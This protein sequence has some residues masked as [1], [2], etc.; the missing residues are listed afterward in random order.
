VLE[1]LAAQREAV[2]AIVEG[3]D[4]EAWRRSVVPTGWTP[5]GLVEHLGGQ[6]RAALKVPHSLWAHVITATPAVASST[7]PSATRQYIDLNVDCR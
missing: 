2:L 7:K 5:A 4:E 6:A 1:F 3:L